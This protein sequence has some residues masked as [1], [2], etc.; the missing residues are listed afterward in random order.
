MFFQRIFLLLFPLILS[1]FS[2][3]LMNENVPSNSNASIE[4][5]VIFSSRKHET[6]MKNTSQ[7][8]LVQCKNSTDCPSNAHCYMENCRCDKGFE[9]D[10]Q[11]QNVCRTTTCNSDVECKTNN[12][13]S[14]CDLNRGVCVKYLEKSIQKSKTGKTLKKIRRQKNTL[15]KSSID[16]SFE[17]ALPF[18]LIFCAFVILSI[19]FSV[20]CYFLR[21]CLCCEDDDDDDDDDD[22]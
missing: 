17:E 13:D 5:S 14:Y 7:S 18:I 10:P 9:S 19:L 12:S 2:I 1:T 22:E 8:G 21:S 3:P 6:D 20:C 4:E 16:L 15:K 11:Q